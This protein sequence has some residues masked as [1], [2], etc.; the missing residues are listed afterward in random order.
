MSKIILIIG[1]S[2]G[3]GLS[4]AQELSQSSDNILICTS[5]NIEQNAVLT[6]NQN[7]ILKNIDV[8]DENSVRNLCAF[9]NEKYGRLDAVIN[10]AGYVN[11]LGIF[12]ISA[13]DWRKT[14][15]INLTGVF[16]VTKYTAAIM[17]KNGGK[18]INIAS[19]A[20]LT[21]RPGWSAY[22]AAKAGV[23]N[24]SSTM[25]EELKAY[26]IRIFCICPGRTATPLRKI[27]APDE[28]PT[29]IM[30]P[31]AV[32]EVI[33]RLLDQEADVLEGQAILVRDR[34]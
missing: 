29:T 28:D 24:F 4:T 9:I 1:A 19:T 20:G 32:A 2:S 21:P 15:E 25:A 26:N 5:R 17:K 13:A 30:Q 27:L 16:N 3:I 12:E 6:A 34:Y 8:A 11:P 18:I 23:I 14:M 33:I 7:I 31:E 22:A 10:C